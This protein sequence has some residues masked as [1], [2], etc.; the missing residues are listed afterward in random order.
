MEI[1]TIYNED[2]LEG[3]RKLPDESVDLIIT[4]PVYKD[5]DGYSSIFLSAVLCQCFRVL[6]DKS[7]FFL[8]FGHLAEDKI[9]PFQACYMAML[10]NFKL[11]DTITWVKNHYRP[12]QGKK[13]LNNLSE[14]IFLLHKGNMPDLDRL[15]IGIPYKDK[16]NAKRFAGG[17]DLKCR[18]NVWE[19]P[20][21]TINKKED[22][23]HNDRFPLLL[24]EL[25][26]KLSGIKDG[27]L[28]LDPFMGSG[29]VAA[30][31]KKLGKN[32]IGFEINKANWETANA[33][34]DK[35]S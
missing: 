6:K 34:I 26:I 1:N 14:F 30:A 21:E 28:V 22:K 24:P 12:I 17:R 19:I 27:A 25:C 5:S 7:L 10:R 8:N 16:S 9:R 13:R 20:Y 33:R 35:M 4:S 31:A 29:T 2:C 23:L 18:G 3:L 11:N 32:Y 15:A